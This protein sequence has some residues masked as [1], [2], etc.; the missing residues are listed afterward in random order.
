MN[1]FTFLSGINV[2]YVTIKPSKNVNAGIV[3]GK[4]EL[5]VEWTRSDVGNI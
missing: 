2:V 1:G 3:Y 4:A 5:H